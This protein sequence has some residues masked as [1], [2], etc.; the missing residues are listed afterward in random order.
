MNSDVVY[1]IGVNDCVHVIKGAKDMN[2]A[3]CL[4]SREHG[5][6]HRLSKLESLLE[7]L[8]T[9]TKN[10]TNFNYRPVA[11][12]IKELSPNETTE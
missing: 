11:E 4:A 3:M 12:L 2:D 6:E 5:L 10:P 1:T 9:W 7:A 8:I